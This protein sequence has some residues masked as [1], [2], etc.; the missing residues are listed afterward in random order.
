MAAS[1][2]ARGT[3]LHLDL[4]ATVVYSNNGSG[5]GGGVDDHHCICIYTF[6]TTSRK[7]YLYIHAEKDKKK[8]KKELIQKNNIFINYIEIFFLSFKNSRKIYEKKKFSNFD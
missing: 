4:L 5:G 1:L 2:K 8:M 7:P 3:S 6:I